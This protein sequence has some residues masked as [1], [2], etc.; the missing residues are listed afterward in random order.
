MSSIY[1][2]ICSNCD[3]ETVTSPDECGAV[4]AAQP[5]KNEKDVAVGRMLASEIFGE[6]AI[7]QGDQLVVLLHPLEESILAGTGYTP[8]DLFREGRYVSITFIICRRCA[9]IFAIRRLDLPIEIGC[10]ASIVIGIASGVGVGFSMK[11]IVAGIVSCGVVTYSAIVWTDIV[12]RKFMQYKFGERARAL[13]ADQLC[14]KCG[15]N[16]SVQFD[17]ARK[18]RCP[19]CHEESLT[20]DMVG[21]S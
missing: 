2:G 18:I 16:D 13:A 11:S 6:K 4:L 21:I 3:Y 14:P 17:S 10:L 8:W 19:A 20:V 7:V 15:A 1:Q 5:A 12:A 9:N